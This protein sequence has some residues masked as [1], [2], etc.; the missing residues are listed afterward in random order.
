MIIS[1]L[2][3]KRRRQSSYIQF[4]APSWPPSR[5]RLESPKCRKRLWTRPSHS[6][7]EVAALLRTLAR[8]CSQFQRNCA[9]SL[10][11]WILWIL[12]MSNIINFNF[13]F[14]PTRQISSSLS[15]DPNRDAVRLLP[16][17]DF[18]N[19][20]VLKFWK[21][22]EMNRFKQ[23]QMFMK[24]EKIS[25]RKVYALDRKLGYCTGMSESH[26]PFANH[27]EAVK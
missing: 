16:P 19:R 17:C 5:Q 20:I 27:L 6:G 26:F 12:K 11:L 2:R 10:F 21:F 1:F 24:T 25:V 14:Y 7:E 23:F 18:E 22:L 13:P 4:P 15:H 9:A 3:T 8:D